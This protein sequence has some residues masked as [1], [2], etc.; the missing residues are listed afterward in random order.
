MRGQVQGPEL[1]LHL[2]VER[3][4]ENIHG[5]TSS[6]VDAGGARRVAAEMRQPVRQPLRK[7]AGDILHRHAR[8]QAWGAKTASWVAREIDA[9]R[10]TC[11]RA[12]LTSP[13]WGGGESP[14]AMPDV[15]P[16]CCGGGS[17]GSVRMSD[18]CSSRGMESLSERREALA[19]K[20]TCRGCSGAAASRRPAGG[21]PCTGTSRARAAPSSRSC[22]MAG[23]CP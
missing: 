10:P 18:P 9:C 16:R 4:E 5:H 1:L 3:G 12:S 14:A 21:A 22:S 20:G 13:G 19:L 2:L 15:P 6:S 11:A 7:R 17:V 8:C 23:S